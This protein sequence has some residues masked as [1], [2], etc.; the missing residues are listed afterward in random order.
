MINM[1]I[2]V[3]LFTGFLESGKTVFVQETL[4]DQRFNT[5][6]KILLI[7]CEE[8]FTELDLKSLN[9]V[10]LEIVEKE[11]FIAG[12]LKL[13]AS[14]HKAE[15][16]LIEYNGMWEMSY[17]Y[18]NLPKNWLL[19]QQINFFDSNNALTYNKNMRNLVVDK[20]TNCELTVFNRM[21]D[22]I[23][24]MELHKLVRA[25]NRGCEIIYEYK[26]GS[27]K[28]DDIEDPLP[29]DINA[30]VIEIKDSDYAIWYANLL[31]H[32]ENY[33]G[34]KINFK[35]IVAVDKSMGKKAFV[36][37]RHVMTC[38]VDDI[39]YKGI[40][41]ISDKELDF[42][43]REWKTVTASVEFGF[44]PM[45]DGDGPLLKLISYNEAEKP[46]EEVAS[47]Y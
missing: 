30:D 37:G 11:E 22:D 16:V 24:Q 45:Y 23:D 41:C 1:E 40:V 36:I 27:I 19:Y 38:C 31:E 43:T 46:E 39:E 15:R 8:G 21:S 9:N 47:F 32:T 42:K 2:P 29:F 5:G 14:K 26:D 17:L 28:I 3:F 35:G 34:K 6:E 13:L 44:H 7:M 25:L 33:I 18:E 12:N 4:E 20:L 10:A